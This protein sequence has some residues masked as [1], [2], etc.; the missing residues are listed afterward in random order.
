MECFSPQFGDIFGFLWYIERR[1]SEYNIVK[2][3]KDSVYCVA[4]SKVPG[5][6]RNHR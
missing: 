6:H 1:I 5:Y 4:Q 2:G 3:E